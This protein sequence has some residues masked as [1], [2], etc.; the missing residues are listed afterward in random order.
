VTPLQPRHP[1]TVTQAASGIWTM[2]NSLVSLDCSEEGLLQLRDAAGSDQ[3]SGPLRIARYADRGEFWDAWDIAADYRTHPLEVRPLGEVQMLEAGPLVCHLALRFQVGQSTVRLD[4]RLRAD[5]PWLELIA[6]VDWRQCHELLR[7][8]LPLATPAVR[9]AADTSGGVVERPARAVTPREQARWEVAA[10]SWVASQSV[11]PGGGV[12]VLLDGPQGVSGTPDQLGVSLLRGPT[13]PDPSADRGLQRSR[14]A[15]MPFAHTW[16]RSAVPQAAIAFREP[17][18]HGPVAWSDQASAPGLESWLPPLPAELCPVA[19][20]SSDAGPLLR[21]LNP[22]A[23]RCRW[24][25]GGSWRV[26]RQSADGDTVELAP[27]ELAELHLAQS[28]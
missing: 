15:L 22:G 23:C 24:R 26:G 6:A 9:V 27:G 16:S 4:L 11:A 1:V 18:W 2:S 25:P 12:A 28:S 8:E 3:L 14:L 20:L 21:V 5:C 19:L 13:W 10:I 17:G 7:I